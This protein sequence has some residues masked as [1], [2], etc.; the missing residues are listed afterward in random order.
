MYMSLELAPQIRHSAE[1]VTPV[2]GGTS[3]HDVPFQRN[4]FSS[5][6]AQMSFAEKPQKSTAEFAELWVQALPSKCEI[7]V[8]PSQTSFSPATHNAGTA[9]IDVGASC[10]THD[11][12]PDPPPPHAINRTSTKAL[13]APS[14]QAAAEPWH[15]LYFLPDPQGHG[16]FRPTFACATTVPCFSPGRVPATAAS[17]AST[18]TCVGLMIA[19]A[20]S[21]VIAFSL[22]SSASNSTSFAY[23]FG[24][25]ATSTGATRSCAGFSAMPSTVAHA[26]VTILSAS[27]R[28]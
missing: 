23:T 26:S 25:F 6:I 8:P 12:L 3:D 2:V 9:N 24:C 28:F 13:I 27:A 5:L 20:V 1:N 17:N 10:S 16:S 14:C 7:D 22:T 19:D 15:F 18:T 21:A 11:E 4:A